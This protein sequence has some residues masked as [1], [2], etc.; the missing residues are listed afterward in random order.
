[1]K[2]KAAAEKH[3][4]KLRCH[5]KAILAGQP[6]A[7]PACLA[8]AEASFEAAFARAEGAGG[9]VTSGDAPIVEGVV[10]ACVSTLVDL[11]PPHPP[12]PTTTPPPT[13]LA[14]HACT[15]LFTTCGGCATCLCFGIPGYSSTGVCVVPFLGGD[16]C[17][18]DPPIACPDDQVCLTTSISPPMFNCAVLCP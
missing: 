9:C 15:Q 17:G 8:A 3:G 16:P 18:I 5:R 14:P 10:D 12:P 1:A 7:D 4:A 11:L 2:L 13:P 6:D